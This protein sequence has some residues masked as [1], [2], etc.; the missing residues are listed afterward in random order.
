MKLL[1]K[2]FL[3]LIF[4]L[5][6]KSKFSYICP[7]QYYR[8]CFSGVQYRKYKFAIVVPQISSTDIRLRFILPRSNLYIKCYDK[9]LTLLP[10]NTQQATLWE[11]LRSVSKWCILFLQFSLLTFIDISKNWKEIAS[12]LQLHDSRKQV[13][14]I[15]ISVPVHTIR[16]QLLNTSWQPR[17][18]DWL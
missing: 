13:M 15:I 4:K 7:F 6:L 11:Q 18:L 14:Y 12:L 3:E 5:L 8:I 9:I 16:T 17:L 2:K 10:Q 1:K